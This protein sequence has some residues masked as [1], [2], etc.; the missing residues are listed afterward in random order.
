MPDSEP[1]AMEYSAGAAYRRDLERVEA[2]LLS[3]VRHHVR[4]LGVQVV[5]VALVELLGAVCQ[6]IV[7]AD[8]SAAPRIVETLGQLQLYV[9]TP[10]G[11][12][13]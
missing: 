5:T 3:V 8:P 12:P 4:A 6:D 11:R 13:Q 1:R 2:D 9:S 10:T 7:T